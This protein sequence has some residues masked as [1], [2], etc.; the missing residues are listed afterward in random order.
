MP[1]KPS[2]EKICSRCGAHFLIRPVD[3]KRG[4]GQF[5][6][7]SCASKSRPMKIVHLKGEK[8]GNWKG[9]LTKSS[10]GYWFVYS[11]THPRANRAG[12]VKRAN[13]VIEAAIGRFLRNDEVVH[14]GSGGKEDDSIENL[15][16][17]TSQEHYRHHTNERR[18]PPKPR[19][20]DAP[21]NRR[22]AWPQDSVLIDLHKSLSLRK[23]AKMI[24]CSH[25]TV[26]RRLK[27]IQ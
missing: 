3:D 15:T 27:R 4:L 7:R 26:D 24:G 13:L 5:C 19:K 11:P 16:L 23:I 12:Y 17:M 10:R 25:K 2:V 8:N 14:H 22:Y 18:V 1:Q 21:Q 20:P 9:G 6:S